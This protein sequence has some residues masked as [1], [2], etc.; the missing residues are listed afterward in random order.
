MKTGE[1]ALEICHS[2]EVSGGVPRGDRRAFDA[3]NPRGL[4]LRGIAW[5]LGL[6]GFARG[7]GLRG[8]AFCGVLAAKHLHLAGVLLS[9]SNALGSSSK[10]LRQQALPRVFVSSREVIRGHD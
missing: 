1:F 5:G 7:L 6:R 9:H 3:A 8:F 4:G 10:L 2:S